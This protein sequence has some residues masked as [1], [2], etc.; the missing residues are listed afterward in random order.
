MNDMHYDAEALQE[1]SKAFLLNASG[2]RVEMFSPY[3]DEA[4]HRLE[5]A[6]DQYDEFC[7]TW[8]GARVDHQREP[9]EGLVTFV[10]KYEERYGALPLIWFRN[11]NGTIRQDVYGQYRDTGMI[12]ASWNCRPAMRGF[13]APAPKDLNVP[14]PEIDKTDKAPVRDEGTA[15]RDSGTVLPEKKAE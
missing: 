9:E 8:V 13:R 15:R 4:W 5:A 12:H 11:I 7:Q 10:E 2:T 1:L 6:G 14:S 3:L